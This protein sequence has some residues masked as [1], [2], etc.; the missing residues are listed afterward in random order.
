MM[1]P[2]IPLILAMTLFIS[3]LRYAPILQIKLQKRKAAG[4]VGQLFMLGIMIVAGVLLF[5]KVFV[6]LDAQRDSDFS[7]AANTTIA[8]VATD[9]YS[10][11][12]LMRLSLIILPVV[13]VFGLLALIKF[14]GGGS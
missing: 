11:V 6:Q 1:L 8:G 10:G 3:I 2:I 13:V 12:D 14:R 4:S 9:F 7:A 5:V